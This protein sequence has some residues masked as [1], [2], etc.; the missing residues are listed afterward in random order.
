MFRV[1]FL[2]GLVLRFKG[3]RFCCFGFRV[4]DLSLGVLGLGVTVLGLRVYI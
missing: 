3:K 4:W 2:W 1:W